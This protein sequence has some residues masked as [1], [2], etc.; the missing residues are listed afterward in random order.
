MVKVT[1]GGECLNADQVCDGVMTVTTIYLCSQA[2]TMRHD[3][4]CVE[5]HHV[6]MEHVEMMKTV[7]H[8]QLIVVHVQNIV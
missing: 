4:F 6:V 1:T 3:Q 7:L 2:F 5:N 8:V